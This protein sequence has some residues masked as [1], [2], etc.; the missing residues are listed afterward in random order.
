MKTI[1][2]WRTLSAEQLLTRLAEL[3]KELLKLNAGVATGVNPANPGNLKKTKK[4]IA[5]VHTLLK[6]QEVRR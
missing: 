1:S 5:R 6:E 3:R 4:N 2:E